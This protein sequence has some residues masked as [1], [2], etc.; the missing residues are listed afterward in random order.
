MY[1]SSE[2]NSIIELSNAVLEVYFHSLKVDWGAYRF[3]NS[4]F[5]CASVCSNLNH[6]WS[7]SVI[8]F[9]LGISNGVWIHPGFV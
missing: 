3:L 7:I 9:E 1:I 6:V 8:L 5:R 2:H 4:P